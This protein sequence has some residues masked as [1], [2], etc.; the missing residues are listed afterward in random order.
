M[1]AGRARRSFNADRDLVDVVGPA[2]RA[3]I[4]RCLGR[5]DVTFRETRTMLAVLSF[6]SAWT[7]LHDEV[8]LDDVVELAGFERKKVVAALRQLVNA[9]ALLYEPGHGRQKSWFGLPGSKVDRPLVGVVRDVRQGATVAPSEGATATRVPGGHRG[10]LSEKTI[11]KKTSDEVVDDQISKILDEL[12]HVDVIWPGQSATLR[13]WYEQAPANFIKRA[14]QALEEHRQGR[15]TSPIALLTADVKTYGI[16]IA[17]SLSS[18]AEKARRLMNQFAYEVETAPDMRAE[19]RESFPSIDD[20]T[21][22]AVLRE[23][24]EVRKTAA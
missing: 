24:Q 23:W 20:D 6:T 10:P 5:T 2:T 21:L 17:D 7:K 16:P 14:R 18:T 1:S 11:E 3:A 12:E 4:E 22:E 15:L 8:Y 13:Q 9:G 19:L